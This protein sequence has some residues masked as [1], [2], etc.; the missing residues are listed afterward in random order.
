MSTVADLQK[1][2]ESHHNV[3]T[4]GPEATV[5]LAAQKLRTHRVGCLVVIN[6]DGHLIGV[7]SERDVVQKV[8]A[9]AGDPS[10]L[11]VSDIMTTQ[12]VACSPKASIEEAHKLMSD[13]NIRHLPIVR[14]QAPVA[15]ISVRDL[16][17]HRLMQAQNLAGRQ[18]SVLDG[19]ET[20]HPGITSIRTD[21]HGRIVI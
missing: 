18:K 5:L 13:N 1:L 17:T 3:L 9:E 11:T 21:D 8:V 7:L 20:Q 2:L 4:I 10:R 14:S 19:L 6:E 12:V 16:L 15:L